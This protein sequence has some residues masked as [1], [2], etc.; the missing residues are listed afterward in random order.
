MPLH[1]D[2]GLEVSSGAES[3][4]LMSWSG[5]AI[6]AGVEAATIRVQAPSK[7]QIG[8]LVPTEN[9]TGRILKHLQ[10][11]MGSRLQEISVL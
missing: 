5:I 2:L 1:D 4:I 3:P 9:V 7:R 8:T 10:M 11:H 6:G